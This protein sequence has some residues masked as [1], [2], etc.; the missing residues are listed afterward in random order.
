MFNPLPI[1]NC[2]KSNPAIKVATIATIKSTDDPLQKEVITYETTLLVVSKDEWNAKEC[3][4]ECIV[5]CMYCGMPK[6]T[7]QEKTTSNGEKIKPV[8]LAILCW[9]EEIS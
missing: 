6:G 2:S 3:T 4:G 8:T 1:K 7:S 5:H 9:S